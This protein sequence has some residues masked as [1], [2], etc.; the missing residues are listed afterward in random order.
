M[1]NAWERGQGGVVSSSFAPG[2]R[3]AAGRAADLEAYDRYIGR[4]SRLSVG[5]E[6]D[7]SQ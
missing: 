4:W 5:L 3:V 1:I 6:P 2:L 7:L